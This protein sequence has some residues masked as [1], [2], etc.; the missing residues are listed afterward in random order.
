MTS[1]ATFEFD[2]QRFLRKL[3]T[4]RDFGEEGQAAAY[5]LALSLEDKL[6]PEIE[7]ELRADKQLKMRHIDPLAFD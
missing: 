2:S 3:D 6:M 4:L 1:E 7:I 5:I